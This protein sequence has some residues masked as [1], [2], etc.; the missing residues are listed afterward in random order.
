[1]YNGPKSVSKR[2]SDRIGK[3]G[4]V[5]IKMYHWVCCC[6]QQGLNY[7]GPLEI[8]PEVSQNFIPD[9]LKA[10]SCLILHF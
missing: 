5:D 10:E 4:E 7:L 1:M 2:K 3:K 6:R 9:I 8:L